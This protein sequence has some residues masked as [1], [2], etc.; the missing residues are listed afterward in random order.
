MQR[1]PDDGFC[2]ILLH[3]KRS[4]VPHVGLGPHLLFFFGGMPAVQGFREHLKQS[5]LLIFDRSLQPKALQ[6]HF[7]QLVTLMPH[8]FGILLFT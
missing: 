1:K 5:D 3:L 7:F 8:C 4:T 2:Q 6:F